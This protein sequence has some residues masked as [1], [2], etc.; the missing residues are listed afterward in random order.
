MGYLIFTPDPQGA[1][2]GTPKSPQR[3]RS[4]QNLVRSKIVI[5]KSCYTCFND[6]KNGGEAE[7]DAANRDN[8][9]KGLEDQSAVNC[10]T[11]TASKQNTK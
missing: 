8:L 4:E 11:A 3:A 9:R 1:Q 2:G 5:N 10:A 7:A 6:D